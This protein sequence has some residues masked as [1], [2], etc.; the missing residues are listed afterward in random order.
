MSQQINL[1][2]AKKN[3]NNNK[4]QIQ[5]IMNNVINVEE[6]NVELK[7]TTFKNKPPPIRS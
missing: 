5:K 4:K 6:K 3:K 2:N 1:N 7:M